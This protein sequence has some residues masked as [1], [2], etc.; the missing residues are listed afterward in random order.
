MMEDGHAKKAL[1][2]GDISAH[3]DD[4]LSKDL[5]KQFKLAKKEA[6]EM[7]DLAFWHDFA[8]Q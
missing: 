4:A 1:A 3:D 8:P 7:A 2:I 5:K 6:A